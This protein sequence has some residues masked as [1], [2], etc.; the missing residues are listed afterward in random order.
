M[1]PAKSGALALTVRS[2]PERIGDESL[3]TQISLFVHGY[4]LC[5]AHIVHRES[6]GCSDLAHRAG[7]LP[8]TVPCRNGTCAQKNGAGGAVHFART[9]IWGLAPRN[10]DTGLTRC[11]ARHWQLSSSR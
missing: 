11:T 4:I 3:M 10:H 1:K 7:N 5:L 9:E 8:L 2:K 6:T